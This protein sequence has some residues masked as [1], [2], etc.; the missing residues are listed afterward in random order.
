MLLVALLHSC[1][2]CYEQNVDLVA[3]GTSSVAAHQTTET[4]DLS[5]LAIWKVPAI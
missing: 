3:L 1:L 4:P 5:A 2:T